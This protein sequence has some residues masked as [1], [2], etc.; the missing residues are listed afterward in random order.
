MEAVLNSFLIV[1]LSEIGDKT[2]LL[3][4]ILATRFKQPKTILLGILAATL[5]NHFLVA[6]FGGHAI[7]YVP[8][9]WQSL[10]IAI[11]FFVFGLW[12]L[13][14]DKM[15]ESK[16]CNWGP[17]LTTFVLFFLAEMG[18]KTQL[19]TMALGAKYQ[20]TF[21][22]TLGSTLGMMA[23]NAPVVYF[24]KAALEKIPLK[25]VRICAALT[26]FLFGIY[27]LWNGVGF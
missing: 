15:D 9:D 2:Q 17:F 18:D 12:A 23:A 20:A 26:F 10:V 25:V 3:A 11:L 8:R 4:L 13:I 22:V 1:A 16:E 5:L 6:S 7:D 14:P 21:A 24:G 27:T 19:A